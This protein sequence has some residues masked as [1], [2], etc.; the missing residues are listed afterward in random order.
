MSKNL[1]TKNEQKK[2][3]FFSA[4]IFKSWINEQKKIEENQQYSLE[5]P[6][7]KTLGSSLFL[8]YTMFISDHQSRSQKRA[9]GLGALKFTVAQDQTSKNSK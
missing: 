9:G 4:S 6:L 2:V 1:W 3:V 7:K 8:N 5:T